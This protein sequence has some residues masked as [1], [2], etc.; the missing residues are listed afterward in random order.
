MKPDPDDITITTVDPDA[1]IDLR[2]AVLRAGLPRDSAI[3]P[4]DDDPGSRHFAAIHRR[5]VIACVTLHL[6]E[7]EEQPAWKLR[8]MAVAPEFQGKGVGARILTAAENSVRADSP[9]R[10]IWCNARV[11]AG[12][13]YEKHGWK[14]VSEV[15][16]VPTAGPHVR[17]VKRL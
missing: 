1:L 10:I 9:I 11:P 14:I 3:F 16:Q 13:F 15:F 4:G 17:M 8:G 7:W 2:H 12:G 6:E 5:R